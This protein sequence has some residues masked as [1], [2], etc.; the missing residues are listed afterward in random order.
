MIDEREIPVTGRAAVPALPEPRG[1]LSQAVVQ[2][3]RSTPPPTSRP[4]PGDGHITAADPTG[5]DL[6][7]ALH[8]CQEL[9][10]RGYTGVHPDW[11][12]DPALHRLR[13]TMEDAYLAYLR[14]TVPG[15][16]DVTAALDALLT[17]T[18]RDRGPTHHLRDDG[19]LW[20]LREYAAHRSVY[21]LK[22]ADP[23][24]FLIPRLRGR[25]KTALAAVENDEYGAGRPERLHA[26]LYADLL[27]DLHLD[28]SYGAYVDAAPAPTL[29]TVTMMTLFGL[30]R[31]LRGAMAGHFAAAEITTAPAARRMAAALHRLGAGPRARLFYTEHIE[32][33]AVHEQVLRHDVIGALLTDEPHLAA[34]IVFGVHATTHLEDRLAAHLLDHWDTGRTSLRR[35]LHPPPAEPRERAR[36]VPQAGR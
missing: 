30:R 22:E 3:L 31:S 28:P 1:V 32:A 35:P 26:A 11:E 14:D 16:D 33:D 2:T 18:P 29:A 21:H 23:H 13:H 19:H 34:D 25:A 24:A 5:D 27:D 12:W 10:Y 7:L 6:Q 17:E 8:T 4:L 9:H 20:Q 36:A 15:G